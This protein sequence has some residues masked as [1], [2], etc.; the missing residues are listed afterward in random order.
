MKSFVLGFILG[1]VVGTVGIS[2]IA[3]ILQKGVSVVQN[4]AK[5]A[6]K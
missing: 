5:S 4:T 6:A 1:I 2:G 3:N